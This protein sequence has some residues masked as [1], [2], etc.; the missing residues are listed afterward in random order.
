M[1]KNL[2]EIKSKTSGDVKTIKVWIIGTARKKFGGGREKLEDVI[3]MIAGIILNKK[4]GDEVEKDELLCTL[5]TNKD[6]VDNIIKMFENAFEIV[7]EKVDISSS[8]YITI[9]NK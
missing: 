6:N 9:L 4:V 1:V 5:H 8:L 2:N 7:N 3:N